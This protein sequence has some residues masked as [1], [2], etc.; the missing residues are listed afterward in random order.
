MRK[1][2][3]GEQQIRLPKDRQNPEW[4]IDSH[5]TCSK[6]DVRLQLQIVTLSFDDDLDLSR[7][8]G[9]K[10]IQRILTKPV[11]PFIKW[12]VGFRNL[13]PVTPV[14]RGIVTAVV[15]FQ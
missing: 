8:A 14:Q 10:C 1:I 5:V 15:E 12:M 2:G 13:Y 3:R 9:L 4:S 6:R 7:Q 11:P